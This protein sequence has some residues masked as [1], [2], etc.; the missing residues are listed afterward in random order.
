MQPCY[1]IEN[2]KESCTKCYLL[3]DGCLNEVL[4]YICR[5]NINITVQDVVLHECIYIHAVGDGDK[6]HP[7]AIVFNNGATM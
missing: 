3:C 7:Y 2:L 6:P 1:R 5:K 4:L